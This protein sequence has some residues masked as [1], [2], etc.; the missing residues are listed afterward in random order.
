MNTISKII[1]RIPKY[2]FLFIVGGLAY[3]FIEILFRGYTYPSMMVLGGICFLLIGEINEKYPW[4]MPLI[5]QMFISMIIV[6]ILEFL[7]GVVLNIILKIGVW[8]YSAMP[9]NLFGQICLLFFVAWF[10]L[11]AVAIILDD[12]IRYKFYGEE[13]PRYNIFYCRHPGEYSIK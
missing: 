3:G 12:I 4:E 8:D 9:Y 13:R 2:L 5:S 7:F 10:F 6:T 11:S 1:S